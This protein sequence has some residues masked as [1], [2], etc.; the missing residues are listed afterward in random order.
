VR[1]SVC[2]LADASSRRGK[3]QVVPCK[4]RFPRVTVCSPGNRQIFV[5]KAPQGLLRLREGVLDSRLALPTDTVIDSSYRLLRVTGSGAFGIT[6][7]AEDLTLATVVAIKEYYPS[8]F[9]DRDAT[10]SVHPKSE[11]HEKTFEWGRASFLNEA[12]T[13]ARFRHPSI[14]RVTRVFEANSTAYMVMDFEGGQDFGAW[15]KSLGRIPTQEELDR[16]AA[17]ILDALAVMHAADFLH[18]DIAPDNIVIRSDGTPVLLD[19]GAA[20]RAVAEVSRSI[21]GIVKAGYSPPEQ[22]SSDNKLQGPWSDIY[23]LG[24]TMYLAVTGRS[25]IESTL[26][27]DRDIMVPAAQAKGAFRLGFLAAI[28]ACLKIRRSERPQSVAQLRPLMLEPKHQ[29]QLSTPPRTLAQQ[30]T[31]KTNGAG[32]RPW[33]TVT[34]SLAVILIIGAYAGY[35]FQRNTATDTQFAKQ[36]ENVELRSSPTEQELAEAQ[37]RRIAEAARRE[38]EQTAAQQEEAQ[39]NAEAARKEQERI[40]AIV[41]AKEK[42]DE[43]RQH[44]EAETTRREMAP[45]I[46]SKIDAAKNIR[47][48]ELVRSG[49]PVQLG[50]IPDGTKDPVQQHFLAALRKLQQQRPPENLGR[51]SLRFWPKN[52]LPHAGYTVSTMTP[53]GKLTCTSTGRDR[54]RDC[55]LR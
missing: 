55:S 50:E 8:E 2:P 22:Y 27:V 39:R 20:R 49:H 47:E 4:N 21:T 42:E 35:Q 45:Q 29:S 37:A 25:P 44:T 43:T 15:L 3:R 33:L 1:N 24:A 7:V 52:S 11:R 12:R 16:I 28:D 32:T 40:A 34:S 30:S 54:P 18:R 51:Y 31:K 6:Y 9:A 36:D 13:L 26:R 46:I 10:M 41:E 19:F 23:A 14:V 48:L 17:L 5:S 38:Q 53:Y